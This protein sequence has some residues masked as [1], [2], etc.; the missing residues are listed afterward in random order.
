MQM[1]NAQEEHKV[2]IDDAYDAMLNQRPMFPSQEPPQ[3]EEGQAQMAS[4]AM[5]AMG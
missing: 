4:N 5:G 3:M 1:M 2:P